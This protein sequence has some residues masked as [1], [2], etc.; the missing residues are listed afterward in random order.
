MLWIK[1]LHISFVV[2]WFAG[3]FYLPRLYVYHA[4]ATDTISHE[5]FIVMERRLFI[6]MTLGAVMAAIFGMWMAIDYALSNY[7]GMGWLHTKLALV[8]GL[9][10]YHVWCWRV[11]RHFAAGTNTRSAVFYRKMNELPVLGLFGIIILAVV[12]PF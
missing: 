5:R 1:A 9:I 6:I 3:L 2:T 8:V 10:A 11:N 12:K 4:D 7:A